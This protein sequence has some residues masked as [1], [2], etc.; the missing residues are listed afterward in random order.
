[1][2]RVGQ[3]RVAINILRKQVSVQGILKEEYGTV[4]FPDRRAQKKDPCA[5]DD[6]SARKECP[7]LENKVATSYSSLDEENSD[8][9]LGFL[10]YQLSETAKAK[11]NSTASSNHYQQFPYS[12]IIQ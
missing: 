10:I 4:A 5:Q 12:S 8:D 9:E 6:A 7:A 11:R 1:M 3:R 2:P